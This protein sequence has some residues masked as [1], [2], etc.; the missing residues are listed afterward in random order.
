MPITVTPLENDFGAVITGVDP[1]SPLSDADF[2]TIHRALVDHIVF[3]IPD[4]AQEFSWMLDLCQR[5]GPLVPHI[6]DQYHH[7]D[8]HECSV[9]SMNTGDAFARG[10]GK[11]AGSYWHSDLSYDADPSDAIFLYGV[12]IPADGGDTEIADMRRAYD[13]LP[14]ATKHRIDG[15]TAIHR[16]GYDGGESVTTLNR[17]QHDA[18]PD[19][20]HPV[21]RTH[22]V[23]GRKAL[24]VSPGVTVRINGMERAESDDL[25]AELFEHALKPDFRYRHKWQAGH[26]V[27]LDNRS[28]MHCAI[29]D[30]KEPRTLYR[31]IVGC[32]EKMQAA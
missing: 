7:P 4:L 32:T 18:H 6:L 22:A 14:E 20:V 8:S 16:Y 1:A 23:N 25:L 11:P 5:F 17:A 13:T 12:T 2:G 19:V 21:V 10:T 15:L 9:I 30:Y 27:G 26:L 24:F 31:F 28:S 3:V 29:A